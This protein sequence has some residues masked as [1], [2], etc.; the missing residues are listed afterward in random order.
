MAHVHGHSADP[1][2]HGAPGG[3]PSGAGAAERRTNRRRLGW[4]LALSAGY[5]LTEVV[6]GWLTG[7][8]ALLADAGHM[9]ADV[10]A[11]AGALL[12]SWIAARPADSRR[13]FGHSGFQS[14]TGFADP[15]HGLAVAIVVNG[16]P[17]ESRHTER[18]REIC[19][20]LYDDL[21]LG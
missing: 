16:N 6:G 14:S 8:L 3:A 20:A 21:G 15:E 12:A 1:A 10:L 17:G 7:S 18:F 2:H 4:A 13:T 11:L 9:L 19:D 5:A